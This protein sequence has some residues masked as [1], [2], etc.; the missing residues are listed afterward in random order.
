[1]PLAGTLHR[2]SHARV[3]DVSP[4]QGRGFDSHAER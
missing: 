3:Q 1:M 2:Y 4:Q